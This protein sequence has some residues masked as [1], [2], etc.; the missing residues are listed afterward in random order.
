MWRARR[1]SCRATAVLVSVL[2]VA[3]SCGGDE[4]EADGAQELEDG[5]AQGDLVERPVSQRWPHCADYEALLEAI[6]RAE[7]AESAI[8]DAKAALEEAGAAYLAAD[9]ANDDVGRFDADQD[10]LSAIIAL[11]DAEAAFA[12]A[13]RDYESA[14]DAAVGSA[15]ALVA[16]TS[17]DTDARSASQSALEAYAAVVDA[18][19][20][21]VH[22]QTSVAL[23]TPAYDAAYGSALA[24]AL[25]EAPPGRV[26]AEA[27]VVAAES[28]VSEARTLAEAA[29]TELESAAAAAASASAAVAEAEA[30]ALA[31]AEEAAAGVL[32]VADLEAVLPEAIAA[33]SAAVGD[34]DDNSADVAFRAAREA[35]YNEAEDSLDIAHSSVAEDAAEWIAEL[36]GRDAAYAAQAA[37]VVR[38]DALAERAGLASD[39]T[40]AHQ[41]AMSAWV[42]AWPLAEA[43]DW[44]RRL[45]LIDF[46]RLY[47][48]DLD[49][50]AE[51][52]FDRQLAYDDIAY[53][54]AARAVRAA[55]ADSVPSSESV[56]AAE[57]EDA[58]WA[59]GGDAHRAFEAARDRIATARA[60]Q[61]G[62]FHPGTDQI[63]WDAYH[64]ALDVLESAAL[65]EA[66]DIRADAASR[67][68]VD[69]ETDQRVVQARAEVERS[70]AAV[71]EAQAR[72]DQAQEALYAAEA[73]LADAQAVLASTRPSYDRA[74]RAAWKTVAAEAGCG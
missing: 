65:A 50:A 14:A 68:V 17:A 64:V 2:I 7:S 18:A 54:A 33:A 12:D 30:A 6:A 67:A 26:T 32:A 21:A 1:R 66:A 45:D 22:G 35:A 49:R 42:A 43:S 70:E 40:A 52:V 69:I 73:E 56:A 48:E 9:A 74:V 41:S 55:V 34:A 57:A 63:A 4:P 62:K 24:A 38:L 3:S 44:L 23:G 61:R 31:D 72:V 51:L 10:R 25:G 60:G 28:A 8:E 46:Y 11:T 19:R 36:A 20:F 58:H 39:L 37:L 13:I 16:D 29:P 53:R 15:E 5:P 47:E 71:A 59:V 27:R